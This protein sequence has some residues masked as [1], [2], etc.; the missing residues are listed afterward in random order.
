[1]QHSAAKHCHSSSDVHLL[2]RVL[3]MTILISC[4][5]LLC[6]LVNLQG[7]LEYLLGLQL[8]S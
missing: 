4:R 5:K 8:P 7:D 1:M 6:L 3:G 2:L